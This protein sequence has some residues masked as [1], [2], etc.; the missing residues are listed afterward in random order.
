MVFPQF[1]N[2]NPLPE[3]LKDEQRVASDK[4][5]HIALQEFFAALA[6]DNP[7]DIARVFQAFIDSHEQSV[8][9]QKDWSDKT[10]DGNRNNDAE[11]K[12]MMARNGQ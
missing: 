3:P 7:G 8:P 2:P 11:M 1:F 12:I 5:A 6:A 10:P 4:E 9:S